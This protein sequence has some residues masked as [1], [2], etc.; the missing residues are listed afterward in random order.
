M[1]SKQFV[2]M[3]YQS[4]I[5]NIQSYVTIGWITKTDYEEITGSTYKEAS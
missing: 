5:T 3:L 4:G 2:K 1:N